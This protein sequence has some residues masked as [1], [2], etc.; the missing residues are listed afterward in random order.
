MQ[1]NRFKRRTSITI[2]AIIS[3][4]A[5]PG[6]ATAVDRIRGQV[7][8]IL[9]GKP[10]AD[11]YVICPITENVTRTDARGVFAVTSKFIYRERNTPG[12]LTGLL[13]GGLVGGPLALFGVGSGSQKA[14]DASPKPLLV[15]A[16]GYKLFYGNVRV[17][18]GDVGKASVV[19]HR[20][21]LAPESGDLASQAVEGVAGLASRGSMTPSQSRP[22]GAFSVTPLGYVIETTLE[23]VVLNR[24]K[25][26]VDVV[27]RMD[28]PP[29]LVAT[30]R[31]Q[32][33]FSTGEMKKLSAEKADKAALT[34]TYRASTKLSA[35]PGIIEAK[36]GGAFVVRELERTRGFMELFEGGLITSFLA[37]VIRAVGNTGS[38]YA[39]SVVAGNIVA[40]NFYLAS[41]PDL[42]DIALQAWQRGLGGLT[43]P[44]SADEQLTGIPPSPARD[45]LSTV[46]Q[47][48]LA[49]DN[50]V[51]L[52][53]WVKVAETA[54]ADPASAASR[55]LISRDVAV[56]CCVLAKQSGLPEDRD[57]ATKAIAAAASVLSDYGP[58]LRQLADLAYALE[59]YALAQGTYSRAAN[60]LGDADMEMGDPT[61]YI[62]FG[63]KNA[64][65]TIVNWF[66]P[67]D[68]LRILIGGPIG[69][70]RKV[71]SRRSAKLMAE[72]CKRLAKAQKSN[73]ANDWLD[74][75][76][77]LEETGDIA[78][79]IRAI[80]T[81]N[82]LKETASGLNYLGVVLSR[83][84]PSDTNAEAELKAYRRACELDPK[85]PTY[86][87]NL[88]RMLW[89]TKQYDEA[90]EVYNRVRP[91]RDSP[92]MALA[93]AAVMAWKSARTDPE[94]NEL[95]ALQLVLENATHLDRNATQPVAVKAAEVAAA[96]NRGWAHWVLYRL[97]QASRHLDNAIA[98]MPNE[99]LFCAERM[100]DRLIAGDLAGA[101]E[102]AAKARSLR[103]QR[104]LLP[105]GLLPQARRAL[106]DDYREHLLH[107]A[108]SLER[109]AKLVARRK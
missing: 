10:I 77:V 81:A 71:Y 61:A 14:L 108:D 17:L 21:A 72:A 30:Y 76:K 90:A 75:S 43:K 103:R 49:G 53:D 80:Q 7:V 64:L 98:A 4:L 52:R 39:A 93:K 3:A 33:M 97:T 69:N 91:P 56:A 5:L 46:T 34:T 24:S 79:A 107:L 85:N 95:A 38:D 9:T 59:D 42:A 101:E 96:A 100:E 54:L 102:W 44:E 92:A 66:N 62:S 60:R 40:R 89:Q 18:T 1:H 73:R 29:D 86:L 22:E 74:A 45:V 23:P 51:K 20:I 12:G 31:A 88:A 83:L 63:P 16:P 36:V 27:V 109:H 35:K 65:D 28:G 37:N 58:G 2:L 8:D 106:V 70:V 105:K 26:T 41:V 82:S 19:V 48:V 68:T 50:V 67:N 32:V 99:P 57:A 47:Y 25:Q 87:S 78:G 13:T 55:G 6:T 104:L 15:L 84:P 11:A 94:A